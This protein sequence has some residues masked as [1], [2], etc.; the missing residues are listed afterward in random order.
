[1]TSRRV[2]SRRVA[3]N[4]QRATLRDTLFAMSITIRSGWI[5]LTLF[6]L[7]GTPAFALAQDDEQAVRDEQARTHFQA[8][9]LYFNDAEYAQAAHEFTRAYELSGRPEMLLNASM[10]HERALDLDNAVAVLDRLLAAHAE[11]PTK[12]Q[13]VARRDHLNALRARMAEGQQV[14]EQEVAE[15]SDSQEV[16]ALEQN[17]GEAE[18]TSVTDHRAP[19]GA[20]SDGPNWLFWGLTAGSAVSLAGAGATYA[21]ALGAESDLEKDCT[22][23]C[24]QAEVDDSGGPTMQTTAFVLAGLGGALAIAAITVALLPED[25]ETTQAPSVALSISPR[26]VAVAG[27]F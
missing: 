17:R 20:T 8:G 5:I 21:L 10:A 14:S 18:G 1:M 22:M 11:L 2:P 27:T 3:K 9:Q 6:A 19:A 26:G 4:A 13:V 25:S 16:L 15:G 24:T 23:G 7:M 12:A